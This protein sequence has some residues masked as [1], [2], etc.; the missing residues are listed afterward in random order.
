MDNKLSKKEQLD[1][2]VE[3]F[4]S[5]KKAD[6]ARI[7]GISNQN[8]NIWYTR[9]YLDIEKVFS[10]C[11]GLSAQWL[12][13]G[14]GEML[15][16]DNTIGEEPAETLPEKTSAPEATRREP[17]LRCTTIFGN[18]AVIKLRNIEELSY[19]AYAHLVQIFTN[20]QHLIVSMTREE[21]ERLYEATTTLN[22]PQP[23]QKQ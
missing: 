9:D 17:A 16:K 5:G 8:L 19:D 15:R 23:G 7:L 6:F 18:Y 11:P 2:L 22:L 12:L 4:A 21:F 1:M 20:R 10:A 3:H 14:Q 13:T